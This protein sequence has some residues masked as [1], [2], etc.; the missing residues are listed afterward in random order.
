MNRLLAAGVIAAGWAGVDVLWA[1]A[2]TDNLLQPKEN[3]QQMEKRIPKR[4]ESRE[5]FFELYTL[6]SP[7]T[8]DAGFRAEYSMVVVASALRAGQS[9]YH[10]NLQR[11]QPCS[12]TKEL[13]ERQANSWPPVEKSN[14]SHGIFLYLTQV[15]SFSL[16]ERIDGPIMR[17]ALRNENW[18]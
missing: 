15:Q 14:N 1:S 6:Y 16:Q 5:R 2:F 12:R 3:K 13:L 4:K 10:G 11:R 17:G 9:G 18:S 8:W 7:K